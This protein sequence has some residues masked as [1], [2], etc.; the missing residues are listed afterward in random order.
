VQQINKVE[1]AIVVNSGGQ[2]KKKGKT[3]QIRKPLKPG[4]TNLKTADHL[5]RVIRCEKGGRELGKNI[6]I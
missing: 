1:L 3:V 5:L 4:H 2:G 6:G